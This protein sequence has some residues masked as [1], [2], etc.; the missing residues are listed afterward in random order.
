MMNKKERAEALSDFIKDNIELIRNKK[1]NELYTKYEWVESQVESAFD[2]RNQLTL[3]FQ[4]I[5]IE[6]LNYVTDIPRYYNP[7]SEGIS[8]LVLPKQILTIGEVAFSYGDFK[9][10][11]FN[12]GLKDIEREAFYSCE[13][14]TSISLPSTIRN[15]DVAAFDYCELLNHIAYNSTMEDFKFISTNDWHVVVP[16]KFVYCT[17]GVLEI[18]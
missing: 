4:D 14:I 18:K 10:V 5:G 1:F 13:E 11:V 9:E 2:M 17:D 15:I 16:A 3:L 12:E 6:V 7:H 8:K